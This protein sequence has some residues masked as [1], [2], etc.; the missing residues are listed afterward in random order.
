MVFSLNLSP[1][2]WLRSVKWTCEEWRVDLLSKVVKNLNVPKPRWKLED[3]FSSFSMF[4]THHRTWK[5]IWSYSTP[6]EVKSL[7]MQVRKHPCEKQLAKKK[8][9]LALTSAIS[10]LLK[11]SSDGFPSD[12]K[13]ERQHIQGSPFLYTPFMPQ[14][15]LFI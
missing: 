4:C 10:N 9:M 14:P 6:N 5:E 8:D 15:P 12:L 3:W 13:A 11:C 1:S 2:L 7:L